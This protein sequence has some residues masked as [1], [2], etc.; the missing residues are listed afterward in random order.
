MTFTIPPAYREPDTDRAAALQ[1]L[2][3]D[4]NTL[5]GYV[6][7][8]LPVD[9]EGR[10]DYRDL[11]NLGLHSGTGRTVPEQAFAFSLRWMRASTESLLAPRRSTFDLRSHLRLRSTK[12][13]GAPKIRT[14]R[15]FGPR[16]HTV[17]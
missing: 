3:C 16:S 10:F 12:H 6:Q 15:R 14:L 5:T 9:P 13:P 1:I 11:F 17:K 2:G 8:G 7:D 4:E